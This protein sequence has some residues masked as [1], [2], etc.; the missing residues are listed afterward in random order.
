MPYCITDKS[1]PGIEGDRRGTLITQYR[2]N[3]RSLQHF[4]F[5]LA[6]AS[7]T[8]L[9]WSF[10]RPRERHSLRSVAILVLGDIGRSPRMMYHAQ[11]FAQNDF[12]TD[13]IGYSGT[14]SC[15][16]YSLLMHP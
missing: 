13:L 5:L 10:F 12:Q 6:L 11:S 9:A 8:W 15:A 3:E 4:L 2:M 16:L 7:L 1:L 14:P